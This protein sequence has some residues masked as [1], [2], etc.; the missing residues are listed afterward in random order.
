MTPTGFR[1]TLRIALPSIGSLPQIKSA[2]APFVPGAAL[3]VPLFWRPKERGCR[4][5]SDITVVTV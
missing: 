3:E 5:I 1:S 2:L 4:N